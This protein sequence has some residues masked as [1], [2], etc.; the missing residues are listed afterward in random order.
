MENISNMPSVDTKECKTQELTEVCSVHHLFCINLFSEGGY[1]E[2][3]TKTIG[4][5]VF[6]AEIVQKKK[7]DVLWMDVEG[8][9]YPI[10]N[11][12]HHNGA[13]DKRG[14][15]ICQMHVEM[16]KDNFKE[17]QGE[18]KKFHDFVW[19]VL[20]DRRYIMLKPVFV[21]FKSKR[22]IR[23]FILNVADKECTDLFLT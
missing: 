12:L 23:T 21:R 20:E 4:A 15:V 17:S 11:Q 13:L 2:E 14:V 8:H 18:T 1:R 19:K 7:I 9:E 10:L 22:Y 16:H 6:F 5:D 3:V